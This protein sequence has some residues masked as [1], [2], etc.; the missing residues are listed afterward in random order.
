MTETETKTKK[1]F[2]LSYSV[3]AVYTLTKQK[4]EFLN[5]GQ[6]IEVNLSDD[7]RLHIYPPTEQENTE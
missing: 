6:A 1:E 2:S 4:L 5:N 3:F 7:C